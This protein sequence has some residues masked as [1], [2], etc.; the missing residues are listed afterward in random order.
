VCS[1]LLIAC[2]CALG[3]A[4]PAALMVGTGRGARRGILIR[5]ISALQHAE[6]LHTVV[7]DKTG[8]LTAGR[9]VVSRVLPLNG[10]D[11]RELLRLAASAESASEHP[12]ARAVVAE[13]KSRGISSV[14]PGDFANEPGL[15]V[16]A[17]VSGVRVLVGSRSLLA[18]HGLDAPPAE[19]GEG[20]EVFVVADG[21]VLG[22]LIV[23]DQLRPDSAAA[24]A[25]LRALGLEPVLLT[26]DRES[27]ARAV[28]EAVGIRH[29]LADV[30]P[31]DKAAAVREIKA[32][33]TGGRMVAMV[34][35]GVN[36]APALAEA[37]LGVAVGSG[38]DVAKETGDMVLVGGSV[39]TLPTAIRLSRATMRVIRQNLFFA[40]F[41]NVLAIP[42]AAFGL[43]NPLIAAA[44]MALSSLSVVAN[45]LRLR[46]FGAV[47]TPSDRV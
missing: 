23:T 27:S 30:K 17:T 3:L 42:L 7:L 28:A 36:D 29:V 26:G 19:M 47:R 38:S 1:V 33:L 45:A 5:D 34:G 44:A 24:V 22:R 12:L 37:H 16:T 32:R 41:Y 43:L 40:F 39:A 13:A 21:R 15:G 31:A 10:T 11:E 18:A 25:Q 8:T 46:R 9:P 14:T 20:S 4:V 35:D 2:P 6:R